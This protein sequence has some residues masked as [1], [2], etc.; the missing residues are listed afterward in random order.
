LGN[1][2]QSEDG[3]RYLWVVQM[4]DGASIFAKILLIAV[5]LFALGP[6]LG[7]LDI[8][9]DGLPDVSVVVT[10]VSSHLKHHP[11]PDN[12]RPRVVPV[13]EMSFGGLMRNDSRLFPRQLVIE[14]RGDNVQPV[15][16]L[17]C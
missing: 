13:R 14:L 6:Q 3:G 1:T 16:P 9:G 10:H 17:R 5:T 15:N 11:W 4:K 2:L 7:S 8:D 12:G